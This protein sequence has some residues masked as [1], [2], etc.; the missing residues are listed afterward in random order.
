MQCVTNQL[1]WLLMIL[2]AVMKKTAIQSTS[3]L[4]CL[5]MES[6][7]SVLLSTRSKQNHRML[8]SVPNLDEQETISWKK[9]HC[10]YV[11]YT[12]PCAVSRIHC[13]NDNGRCCRLNATQSYTSKNL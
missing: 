1:S 7:K 11:N 8:S 13:L 2:E 9:K 5:S 6:S 10:V 12:L 3:R 4:G